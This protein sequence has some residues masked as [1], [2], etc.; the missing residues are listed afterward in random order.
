[1]DIL[2][3]VFCR[4]EN[5]PASGFWARLPEHRRERLSPLCKSHFSFP[6]EILM[7]ELTLREEAWKKLKPYA[8]ATIVE[9]GVYLRY[10][11][12]VLVA[13]VVK[14][15]MSAA[16]AES[17]LI[18]LV[19]WMEDLVFISSFASFFWRLLIR[20]YKETKDGKI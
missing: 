2:G 11:V 5:P 9:T 13:Q 18:T 20:L 3:V 12:A 4:Q 10:W 16:G 6:R 14:N 7:P 19:G 15:V 17:W 8:L 1:M